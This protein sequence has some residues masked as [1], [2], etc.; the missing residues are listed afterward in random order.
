MRWQESATAL[1]EMASSVTPDACETLCV[2]GIVTL[3]KDRVWAV[4]VAAAAAIPAI[5]A[6]KPPRGAFLLPHRQ[7]PLAVGSWACRA[8]AEPATR[9]GVLRQRLEALVSDVSKWV[10]PVARHSLGPFLATLRTEDV[11]EG[12]LPPAVAGQ[13]EW[14]LD[15]VDA[16][17]RFAELLEHFADTAD[18]KGE[19]ATALQIACA[20]HFPDVSEVVGPGKWNKLCPAL[21]KLASAPEAATRAALAGNLHRLA[22][23]LPD[24]VCGDALLSTTE[25]SSP[26]RAS[27]RRLGCRRRRW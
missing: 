24:E 25:V 18:A 22:E 17:T 27:V 11:S 3:S 14:P 12:T 5:A 23:A 8:G 21:L 1:A 13:R 10:R 4:R 15:V 7:L 9:A 26:A 20:S 16:E 2:R 6:G 19:D